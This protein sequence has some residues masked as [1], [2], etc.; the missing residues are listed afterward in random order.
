MKLKDVK[1]I[2]LTKSKCRFSITFFKDIRFNVFY[3][4]SVLFYR[5]LIIYFI[6][7]RLCILS[8]SDYILQFSSFF[9]AIFINCRYYFLSTIFCPF[10]FKFFSIF[11]TYKYTTNFSLQKTANWFNAAQLKASQ[12]F[13]PIAVILL[14]CP[15]PQ[16]PM[17][18]SIRTSKCVA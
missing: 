15:Y 2:I 11:D 12:F 6:D 18:N 7:F 4:F 10:S 9:N 8:V 1:K 3:R 17:M 14:A 5:F 13:Q 16:K